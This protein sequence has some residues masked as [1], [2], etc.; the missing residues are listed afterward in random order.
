MSL[1][2]GYEYP[3]QLATGGLDLYH[4]L[5]SIAPYRSPK[6]KNCFYRDGVISRLGM[7][8]LTSTEVLSGKAITSLHRFYYGA[9][10][11]QLLAAS[12]T[13]VKK[14]DGVSAWD[15]VATGLTDGAQVT[16]Y[17]WGPKDAVYVANGNQTTFKW[18]GTTKTNL[19]AF[20]SSTKQF[21]AILDR[22]VWIDATNPSFIQYTTAFDDTVVEAAQNA[23]KVPGPGIIHGLAYHGLITDVGFAYKTIVAK[24]SSVWLLTANDLTPASIDARLDIISENIGCE[25][26]R[27][28]QSTPIGTIFLG[29][30]RQ[31]YLITYDMRT[32][33]IGSLIRS[34]R[35]NEKGIEQIPSGQMDKPFAVYHDGFYKLYIPAQNGTYNT[36]QYWL[37]I[38]RFAQAEDGFWGPW[39]GPMQGQAIAHAITQNGPGDNGNL[40]GG[41]ANATT[42]SYVYQLDNTNADVSTAINYLY[43]TN[44]DS[45]KRPQYNK[46]VHSVDIELAAVD[47]TLNVSFYDTTGAQSSGDSIS[48][49]SAAVYWGDQ[50]WNDFFWTAGGIPSRQEIVPDEKLIVRYLS[51]VFD[52]TSTSEQ[53]E[54]YS[55]MARGQIRSAIPF[56]GATS[57]E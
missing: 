50:D 40:M 19:G 47:G 5:T 54:L 26:W 44:F 46:T 23:L 13:T 28:I 15:N 4:D 55:I 18:D 1:R 48:L 33:L 22:L 31:V 30:D 36:L 10:S 14:Y 56:V 42:G 37:D 32:V 51:M 57:R 7:S 49:T 24:G 41:E 38:T 34:N 25:A 43:Q 29:T 2:N 8:R 11:K 52:F 20:P 12:G 39:Y 17:T 27:T 45:H 53:F 35:V 3:Y 21:I 9:S 6:T 16:M